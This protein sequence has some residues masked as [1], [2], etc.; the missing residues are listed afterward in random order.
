MNAAKKVNRANRTRLSQEMARAG[1][2]TFMA[3][4]AA[5]L[6]AGGGDTPVGDT[7]TGDK[8]AGDLPAGDKPAGDKPAGDAPAGDKPAGDKPAAAGAPEAYADFT[9]PDGVQLD[10]TV[11]G[12][13]GTLAKDLNLPQDKAQQ[14][15]DLHTKLQQG[16]AAAVKANVESFYADIGGMPE[17][18]AAT[19][20]ADKEFGGDKFDENLAVAKAALEKFG[21]PELE[22]F[23]AKTGAGTHPELIRAF[24]RVGRAI[25]EDSFVPGRAGAGKAATA[26]SM[27]SAS[28]MNP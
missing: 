6:P 8:P 20:R 15:V 11:M 26:Q 23:L 18:W 9:L 16:Q 25:S 3:D 4:P 7:P 2:A 13:F 5:D 22:T 24:V 19:A 27:Y 1:L 28:N 12:E 14:L 21:T 10:A 17:T